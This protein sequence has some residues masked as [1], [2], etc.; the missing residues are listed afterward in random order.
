MQNSRKRVYS[1]LNDDLADNQVFYVYE[2]KRCVLWSNTKQKQFEN[3]QKE[4]PIRLIRS[5]STNVIKLFD[6]CMHF[7]ALNVE[8]VDSFVGFSEDIGHLIYKECLKLGKFNDFTDNNTIRALNVFSI[9]YPDL[10]AQNLNLNQKPYLLNDLFNVIK[11]LEI[12]QLCLQNCALNSSNK[13]INLFELLKKS[14]DSLELLDVSGNEL[15]DEYI[16]KL[17]LPQRMGSINF[18]RLSILNLSNNPCL[19]SKSLKYLLKFQ[20]LNQIITSSLSDK[21]STLHFKLCTCLDEPL[22]L[23]NNSGWLAPLINNKQET[24]YDILES[25][26]NVDFKLKFYGKKQKLEE[27]KSKRYYNLKKY[28]KCIKND[29]SPLNKLS[30]TTYNNNN[31]II[32]HNYTLSALA[33]SKHEQSFDELKKFYLS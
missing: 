32:K 27:N 13:T 22:I 28:C 2:K 15:D 19:S 10:L 31:N 11:N 14:S 23:R 6:L 20:N 21:F 24:H 25:I 8:N 1:D 7:I 9:A 30:K 16:M 17:T 26:K 29:S 4:S 5:N 33:M 18:K 3:H 12:T